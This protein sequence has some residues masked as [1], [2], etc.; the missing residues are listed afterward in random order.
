MKNMHYVFAKS[1]TL[2][3]FT[4]LRLLPK[5]QDQFYKEIPSL[6]VSGKIN[7][8]EH[9]WEGLDKVGEAILAVQKGENK[10]KAVVHVADD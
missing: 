7:H 8:R 10:A 1:I 3:G 2:Y 4:V 6:V 9:V 5:Y